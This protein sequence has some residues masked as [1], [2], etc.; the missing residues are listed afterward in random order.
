MQED[1]NDPPAHDRMSGHDRLQMLQLHHRNTLWIYWSIIIIGIWL[2]MA[3]LT[4][5]Y[6]SGIAVPPGGRELWLTNTQRIVY[7]KWNDIICGILL[8]IFGFRSLLPSRPISLWICCFIGVW[9]NIE[10]LLFWA[11]QPFIYLNDTLCGI[12]LIAL[13]V[14]IPGMPNMILYMKM[15]SEV[16]QGWSYN[17]SSWPQ[18]W[19]MIV[20]GFLGFIVSRYLAGWQ[21]GYT[22][23]IWEPFFKS[24]EQVLNSSMSRSLFISDAGLGALAYTFE[25]LMGFMGSPS[26]WRTMPWMV[27]FFGILVIPLGLVHIFLVI[28]QPLV[29]GEWC[30]FCLLAACIM[31]PMIPLEV[32]EVVAMGQHIAQST[33]KGEKFWSVFWKG[34]TPIE[35][36][37]DTRSPE[38]IELNKHGG[39]VFSS[40]LWGLSAPWTLLVSTVLGI[41]LMALPDQAGIPIKSGIADL[42][43][44]GGALVVVFSVISF[45][46]VVRTFRLLNVIVGSVISI[47]PWIIENVQSWL[48][49]TDLIAGSL[50]I[51]LSIP[52]GKIKEQYGSWNK[53]IF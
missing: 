43:H 49:F 18:R 41:G 19:I 34:G 24:S 40:S 14:L 17:P 20:T 21:L 31:L 35:K 47:M 23:S 30:T 8:I 33:R 13:S 36:N 7:T 50:I 39:K 3:P 44:L 25:F 11:P 37:K 1:N 4:F 6:A 10:P 52:R 48:Q 45:G 5:G 27:T 22:S 46:E 32:D 26:R 16:P 38:L 42:N 51:V 15:G 9:L 28:S 2:V 12:L 53:F 29:V